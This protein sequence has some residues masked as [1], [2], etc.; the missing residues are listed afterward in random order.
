[1]TYSHMPDR[2]RI[3]LLLI[4][5][6]MTGWFMLPE[7]LHEQAEPTAHAAAFTVT[8]TNDS[9]PGSLRQ[10]I[11]DANASPG[12]DTIT[13]NFPQP[14]L[15]T[16]SPASPLP[17]II[18]PLVINGLT[19][20]GE[21]QVEL[22]GSLAGANADGLFVNDNFA[23]G[24]NVTIAGLVINRF[25]SSGI[26]LANTRLNHVE[27]NIIGTNAAM[28][29]DLGNGQH[30]ILVNNSS[31]N[32][33]TG[34]VIAANHASGLLLQGS[35]ATDNLL[36]QNQIGIASEALTLGNQTG[37]SISGGASNNIVGIANN[38]VYSYDATD[39][40]NISQHTGDG[41]SI[42]TSR[43]TTGGVTSHVSSYLNYSGNEI[44]NNA[45]AGV[46]VESG[47]GNILAGNRIY[48]NSGAGV[49]VKTPAGAGSNSTLI[50]RG[51]F[52]ENGGLP[53]D[54]APAGATANDPDDADTGANGL[55]NFPLLSSV[56]LQ[57]LGRAHTRAR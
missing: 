11:L 47:E 10:A 6:L 24:G 7:S 12:P 45:G 26:V 34:N 49:F 4:L 15:N 54:L 37:V 19:P 32:V 57:P 52:A 41:L 29:A 39:S 31:S 21:F 42:E 2:P 53:I 30:G 8:N 50:T 44:A 56:R 35:G 3:H 38:D 36:N 43:N 13:F 14:G 22:D 33:I 55:Q 18:D 23:A 16:I 1:M 9:G 51:S 48:D 20:D 40:N 28:T 27:N 5:M 17:V 25:G 46:L